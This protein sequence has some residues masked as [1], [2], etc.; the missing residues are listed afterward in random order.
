MDNKRDPRKDPRPGDVTRDGDG[1][2]LVVRVTPEEVYWAVQDQRGDE[3]RSLDKNL[4]I[5]WSKTDEVL[6]VAS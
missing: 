3:L 5:N 6:H 1:V 2:A 4:W